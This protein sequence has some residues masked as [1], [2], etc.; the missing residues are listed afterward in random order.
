MIHRRLAAVVSAFAA[1]AFSCSFGPLRA[2]A[3]GIGVPA[4]TGMT[5]SDIVNLA[6][7]YAT[8]ANVALG[9]YG[10]Q[11]AESVRV[12][13]PQQATAVEGKV[14]RLVTFK[15]YQGSH[16]P[17]KLADLYLRDHPSANRA[18]IAT[19]FDNELEAFATAIGSPN[20]ERMIDISSAEALLVAQSYYSFDADQ[21]SDATSY[22]ILR[23]L[24][25]LSLSNQQKSGS[26]PDGSKQDLFDTFAIMAESLVSISEDARHRG[27]D[28]TFEQIHLAAG[29]ILRDRFGVDPTKTKVD[30]IICVVYRDQPCDRV[31]ARARIAFGGATTSPAGAAAPAAPAH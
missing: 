19:Y 12:K 2:T 3:A 27:D 25:G 1:V 11:L 6:N 17:G 22:R 28:K 29:S 24:A 9:R 20:R 8:G 5:A 7:A 16:V 21:P 26:W 15:R 18:A 30:R 14:R 10:P 23:A 31:L 13:S 4:P